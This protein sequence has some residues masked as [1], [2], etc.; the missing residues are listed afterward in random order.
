MAIEELEA[1]IKMSWVQSM[2]DVETTRQEERMTYDMKVNPCTETNVRISALPPPFSFFL[3]HM[4]SPTPF[5]GCL[6]LCCVCVDGL[7]P[8][9]CP[10]LPYHQHS[11][12]PATHSSDRDFITTW[13]H[14]SRIARSS[15]AV[16]HA[17]LLRP[18]RDQLWSCQP[19]ID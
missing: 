12:T 14:P 2:K 5:C 19:A 1:A 17:L 16:V 11:G 18:H 10:G 15:V 9:S 4:C 7:S 3:L 6:F 8:A 13:V